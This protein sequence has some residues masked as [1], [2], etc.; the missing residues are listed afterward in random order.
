MFRYFCLDCWMFAEHKLNQL[1]KPI[2]TFSASAPQ[3]TFH[4]L[5]GVACCW[6]RPQS[7]VSYILCTLRLSA[8]MHTRYRTPFTPP[9]SDLLS[10]SC[11]AYYRIYLD[12]RHFCYRSSSAHNLLGEEILFLLSRSVVL[13]L[14][15]LIRM[16][17]PALL[18]CSMRTNFSPMK[19]ELIL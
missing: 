18:E 12:N 3:E 9:G 19:P 16:T 5:C 11:S 15:H 8:D 17:H 14:C 2:F 7:S 6:I 10:F 13:L 1:Y 4:V